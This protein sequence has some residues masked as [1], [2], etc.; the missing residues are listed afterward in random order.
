MGT[1]QSNLLPDRHP[2]GELFVC[3]IADCVLKN[4]LASMEHPIFSLSK[5]PDLNIRNYVYGETRLTVTPSVKGL[6]TIWD[7]DVLIFAISQLMAAKNSG[8][9]IGRELSLSARACLVFSNRHTGGKDYEQLEAALDRLSGTRLRTTIKTGGEHHDSWFGLIE[10]AFVKRDRNSGRIVEL[11]ITLSEWLFNAVNA[12][13]VLSMHRDYFRLKKAIE[14]RIYEISR[15]HCGKSRCWSIGVEK[16][17]RKS[18]SCGPLKQFRYVLRRLE[19]ENALPG[20]TVRLNCES[21]TVQFRN[22]NTGTYKKT[23]N[24]ENS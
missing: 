17:Y 1:N 18:G 24:N 15:K 8:R 5:K 20:Y 23:L 2:Q 19:N 6:A 13:E 9:P 12:N 14:R 16:L 21:D 3:D 10:T 22:R 4:D 11:K 7:K